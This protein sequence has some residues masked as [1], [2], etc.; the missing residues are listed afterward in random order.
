VEG[1]E[2]RAVLFDVFGTLVDW[3]GGVARELAAFGRERGVEADWNAFADAWRAAYVPSMERVRRGELPWMNLD[4]LQTR[5]FIELAP[6]FGLPALDA[7]EIRRCV[8]GWHRLDP[9]PGVRDGLELLRRDYVLATLSN[10]NLSLLID[11]ARR[12]DLRFDAL[13]CSEVFRHYKPD[14]ETYLGASAMLGLHPKNV[15]LVAAH[16]G[17][18]RAAASQGLR[19][20]FFARPNEFGSPEKADPAPRGE[21][22]FVVANF[23]QLAKELATFPTGKRA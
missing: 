20:A 23:G 14:P 7:T 12:G 3:R 1:N 4:E 5:S 13:L 21:V 6:R 2:V 10:G 17:D 18:L 9:W 8:D 22:D 19:T 11:L 15:V 16:A